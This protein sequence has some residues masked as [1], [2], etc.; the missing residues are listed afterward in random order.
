MEG[1][2]LCSHPQLLHPYLLPP[3][4]LAL[5]MPPTAIREISRFQQ[6]TE[7]KFANVHCANMIRPVNM[8]ILGKNFCFM[9]L[10]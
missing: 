8:Q 5:V 3:L 10:T 2:I 9:Q 7:S 4:P 1:R 6:L